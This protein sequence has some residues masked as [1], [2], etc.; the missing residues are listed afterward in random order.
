VVS[1]TDED[2]KDFFKNQI[3]YWLLWAIDGH[4]KN[5]SLFVIDD[6]RG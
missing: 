1:R 5:F 4:A 2:R 6:A 3:L